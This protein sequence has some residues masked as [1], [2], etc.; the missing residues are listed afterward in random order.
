MHWSEYRNPRHCSYIGHKKVERAVER[1]VEVSVAKND[2][3]LERKTRRGIVSMLTP[4]ASIQ[5]LDRTS[6]F[7]TARVRVGVTFNDA[8]CHYQDVFFL[9]CTLNRMQGTI[10]ESLEWLVFCVA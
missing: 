10:S 5:A 3:D 6:S 1:G 2:R 4:L 7:S 8:F 9:L